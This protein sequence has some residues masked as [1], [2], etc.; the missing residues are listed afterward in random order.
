MYKLFL[1]KYIISILNKIFNSNCY[2]KLWDKGRCS[3]AVKM[4][5]TCQTNIIVFLRAPKNCKFIACIP[6]NIG[7]LVIMRIY[8]MLY[9]NLS[10]ICEV[11]RGQSKIKMEDSSPQRFN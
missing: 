2:L 1:G 4:C 11:F 6:E 9:S 3:K 5:L 7:R 10:I 8:S